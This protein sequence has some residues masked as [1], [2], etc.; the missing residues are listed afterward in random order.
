[1]SESATLNAIQD[2]N[3][4]SSVFV[5]ALGATDM[6]LMRY[7]KDGYFTAS[8]IGGLSAAFQKLADR[9]NAFANS[10]YRMQY[11]TPKRSGNHTVEVQVTY[12]D[13]AKVAYAGSV[14]KSFQATTSITCQIQ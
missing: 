1:V 12:T 8:D 4:T 2:S 14:Q 3:N 6:T 13:E 10:F 7:G 11:C 9:V 5:V